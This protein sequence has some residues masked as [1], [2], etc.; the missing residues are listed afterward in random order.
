M[1]FQT[2][3]FEKQKGVGI[4]TLNRI[5][6][7]NALNDEMLTE[8]SSLLD[9]IANDDEIKS[10]IITGGSRFFSAGGDISFMVKADPLQA[11]SF[12]ELCHNVMNKISNLNKPVI[13]SIAGMALG[14]G[15]EIALACDI[16]IA[17]NNAQIGLPEINLAL[18]PGAGG[19]QRLPKIVGSGWA[20]QLIMTGDTIDADTAFRIGL[21]TKVVQPELLM[22]ETKKMAEKLASKSPITMR[23]VKNVINYGLGVD[24]PSG[25]MFE[26]KNFAFLFATE[27]H[28]EGMKAFLEKRQPLFKGR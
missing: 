25:L 17:A 26:Q 16:R 7:Y 20:K 21:V 15:C 6:A 11:E 19:T 24:L 5:K 9:I 2:L 13:A 23:I 27:D 22:E 14:G 4:I 12:V 8:L 10:V 3:L 28:K 18:F 1:E